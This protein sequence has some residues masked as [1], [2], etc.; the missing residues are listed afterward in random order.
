M[1][2]TFDAV[3]V[4]LNPAIDRTLTIPNFAAGQVNRVEN[5]RTKPG[6][7]G[8]NVASVLADD[9]N[10]VAV[11]GFLGRDNTW[12]F[13]CLFVQK[14]IA[15]HFVRIAGATRTGIKITD[16]VLRQ[17]TDIN[18]PGAAPTAAELD[19]LKDQINRLEAPW[20]VLSGS[21]PAGVDTATYRDLISLLRRRGA[22]VLLDASGPALPLALE[23]IPHI[24]KPN[25]FEL[26]ELAGK[27]LPD[28]D[29]IIK[30]VVPWLRQGVELIAVSMGEKGALFIDHENVVRAV[31]PSVEVTSTVGAGDAMVAGIISAQLKGLSLADCARQ[32]TA[33]SIDAITHPGT[34]LSSRALIQALLP[35][36]TLQDLKKVTL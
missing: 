24:I 30:A 11:T 3:T 36:I 31:P 14:K 33:F 29:A 27:S 32:A 26:E 35:T 25:L 34:G 5:E 4:T 7:K 10:R 1:K 22:R 13:Q 2:Q 28:E 18:F 17:T 21:L 12:P 23:A 16:P 15:D 9:G 8:V 19:Q 20:Y 6:G